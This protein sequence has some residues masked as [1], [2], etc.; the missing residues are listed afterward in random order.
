MIN[1][2]GLVCPAALFNVRSGKFKNIR[3]A[4]LQMQEGQ[5]SKIFKESVKKMLGGKYGDE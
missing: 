1:N 3:E 5:F 4:F 2:K